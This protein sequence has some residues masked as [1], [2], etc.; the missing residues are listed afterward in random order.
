MLTV[1]EHDA[2]WKDIMGSKIPNIDNNIRIL[3]NQFGHYNQLMI[4]KELHG[5]KVISDLDYAQ[6][7][8]SLGSGVMLWESENEKQSYLN[9]AT[10]LFK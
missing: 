4:V 2:M 10:E 7:L 8:I 1:G 5:L 6:A 3:T 9:K